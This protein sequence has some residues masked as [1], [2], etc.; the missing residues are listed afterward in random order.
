M[1]GQTEGQTTDIYKCIIEQT[2][3][4]F[5]KS[6]L[7]QTDTDGVFVVM[8]SY[9]ISLSV[10]NVDA[11]EMSR[12]AGLKDTALHNLVPKINNQGKQQ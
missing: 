12:E 9:H 1:G 8:V 5:F 11:L 10:S 3:A 6:Q 4:L 2:T 7:Q